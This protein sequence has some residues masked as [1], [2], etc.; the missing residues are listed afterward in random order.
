VKIILT[1]FDVFRKGEEPA[2]K[3]HFPRSGRLSPSFFYALSQPLFA[4]IIQ[5]SLDFDYSVPALNFYKNLN[6][7]TG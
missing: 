7:E 1:G 5:S 3:A 4:A 6:L 2:G